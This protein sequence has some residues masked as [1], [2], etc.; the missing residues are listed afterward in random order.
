MK[1]CVV[2]LVAGFLASA[3]PVSATI[4]NVPDDQPTIQAGIDASVDGDTVLVAPGIYDE[5]VNIS[6]QLALV[7][8]SHYLTTGNEEFISTT[9]IDG[10]IRLRSYWEPPAD[11]YTIVGFTIQ[12]GSYFEHGIYGGYAEITITDNIF[13]DNRI[14]IHVMGGGYTRPVYI[15]RN[16]MRS[17]GTA[18]DL[19]YIWPPP[20]IEDNI[21]VGHSACLT[22]YG[23]DGIFRN[24]TITDNGGSGSLFFFDSAFPHTFSITNSILWG[25]DLNGHPLI[26]ISREMIVDVMY[27]DI[28]GGWAGEGNIDCDPMFCD[29]ENGNFYLDATSCCVGAGEGGVDIGAL[30][31]GCGQEIPTLSEWGAIILSLLLLAAGTIAIVRRRQATITVH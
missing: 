31:I 7:L 20:I 10:G 6:S 9:V 26:A 5:D 18:L 29:P 23:W 2:I 16:L 17:G 27:S 24:N 15:A 1:R 30:G 13:S 12:N 11:Y 4:I 19:Y 28:Q 14:D 25:N 22:W 3:V 8:A 21:V